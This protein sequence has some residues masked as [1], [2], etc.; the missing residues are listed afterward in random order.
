MTDIIEKYFP[1]ITTLQREQ[2]KSLPNLYKEWN[3]R[4]NVIS[5]RDIDNVMIHHVLHSL[6]IAKVIAFSPN[7]HILDVGTGGGFPGIPLAIMFPQTNFSLIDS[8]G[9][10]ILVASEISKAIGLKNVDFAHRNAIDEKGKYD[11]VI[12]RAVMP[13]ADLVK[14]TYKNIS[15]ESRNSLMNG[16]ITLKGG[17]LKEELENCK[18]KCLDKKANITIEKIEKW[19]I[20]DFF[21]EDYFEEKYVIHI[22][23]I[24]N[25]TT[26]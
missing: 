25:K 24:K 23:L 4:I 20:H 19:E 11:Y 12:T 15:S 26:C 1:E 10:K 21:S 3:S 7:T 22:P 13:A 2:F 14:M 5:R 9:K 6:S 8:I 17:N 16:I 18:I